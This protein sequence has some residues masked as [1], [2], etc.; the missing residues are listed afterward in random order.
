M[1]TPTH[2]YIS[3]S[4]FAADSIL[5]R[6]VQYSI[7][8]YTPAISK[9]SFCIGLTLIQIWVYSLFIGLNNFLSYLT[10]IKGYPHYNFFKCLLFRSYWKTLH[11]CKSKTV[12]CCLFTKIKIL[13]KLVRVYILVIESVTFIIQYNTHSNCTLI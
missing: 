8:L 9:Y 7:F 12:K 1:Y 3:L 5:C 4:S 11:I 13:L 6:H 10:Q 2:I